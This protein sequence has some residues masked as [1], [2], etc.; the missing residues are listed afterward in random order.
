MAGI[1][2]LKKT[3]DQ[4]TAGD[5]IAELYTW[6]KNILPRAEEMFLASTFISDIQPEAKP[7]VFDIIK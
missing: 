3:G 4:V 7:L 1:I 6:K 5:P 2:L